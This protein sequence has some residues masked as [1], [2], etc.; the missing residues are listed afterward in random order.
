LKITRKQDKSQVECK[1]NTNGI[2]PH[3]SIG[4]F[5]HE[6]SNPTEFEITRFEAMVEPDIEDPHKHTFYEIIWFDDGRSIQTIDYL[7]PVFFGSACNKLT[8]SR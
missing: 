5:I 3:Y 8:V 6:P 2:F 4:H 1:P 7:Q